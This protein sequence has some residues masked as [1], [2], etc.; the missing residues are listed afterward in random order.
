MATGQRQDPNLLDGFDLLPTADANP[1]K[2]QKPFPEGKRHIMKFEVDC[3]LPL[4]GPVDSA[5]PT[6]F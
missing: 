2:K 3:G 5:R 6:A 1:A 4:V